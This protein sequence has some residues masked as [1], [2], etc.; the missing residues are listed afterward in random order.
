MNSCAD[1]IQCDVQSPS[2]KANYPNTTPT[3][4]PLCAMT[5]SSFLFL[6]GTILPG[7]VLIGYGRMRM[8]QTHSTRSPAFLLVQTH[9]G[10][11]DRPAAPR[12]STLVLRS[13]HAERY[14]CLVSNAIEGRPKCGSR[15]LHEGIRLIISVLSDFDNEEKM[16]DQASRRPEP[17]EFNK[18]TSR[19]MDFPG[20]ASVISRAAHREKSN[21]YSLCRQQGLKEECHE[22]RF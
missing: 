12:L 11:P 4:I 18:G 20:R 6:F 19:R 1:H 10:Q 9:K 22:G 2:S 21:P 5:S 16:I 3:P 14:S 8:S 17:C 7:F 15:Y 13:I